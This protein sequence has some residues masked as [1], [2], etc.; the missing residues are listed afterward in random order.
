MIASIPVPIDVVSRQLISAGLSVLPAS[1]STK[2]PHTAALPKGGDG[3][4]TWNPFRTRYATDTELTRWQ[5]LGADIPAIVYGNQSRVE[6]FDVDLKGDRA[7][8]GLRFLDR[9]RAAG[10]GLYPR[11]VIWRSKSGGMHIPIGYEGEIPGNHQIARAYSPHATDP[12]KVNSVALV[13]TRGEGGYGIFWPA[14]GC[15]VLQGDPLRPPVLTK[16]E[17]TLIVDVALGFE[18]GLEHFHAAMDA[19]RAADEAKRAARKGKGQS[20]DDGDGPA[21]WFNR[22]ATI[23]SMVSLL[24]EEG[25]TIAVQRGGHVEVTRTGKDPHD[26]QSGNIRYLGDRIVFYNHSTGW[27]AFGVGGYSSFGVYAV[28][29]HGGSYSKAGS[30]IARDPEYIRYELDRAEAAHY[31]DHP[32]EDFGGHERPVDGAETGTSQ[33]APDHDN[34]GGA[35]TEG[36]PKL[37][38]ISITDRPLRDVTADAL[39]ALGGAPDVY[40]RGGI[41]VRMQRDDDMRPLIAPLGID[42]MA[43]EL[44]RCAE[45]ARMDGRTK[46]FVVTDPPPRVV[47]DVLT[48]PSY[49]LR[50]LAGIVEVPVVRADGSILATTGYDVGSRLIYD[51]DPSLRVPPVPDKP[52][53]ADV[54]RART[55][56]VDELLGEFPFA[57]DSDRAHAAALL[58]EGFLLVLIDGP[59]PMILID[60]PSAGTGK[61]LIADML[62]LPAFGTAVGNLSEAGDDAEWRKRLTALFL[63]GTRLVRVDNITQPLESASLAMALT[64]G[65]WEDRVLGASTM[66]RVP[67]R[68]VW[69]ATGNNVVASTDIARRMVPIRL[70]AQMERPWLRDGFRHQDLRGWA[71]DHRGDLV[72]AALILIRA[73]VNAGMPAG[74]H[75]R[76]GSYESWSRVVGGILHHAGIAGFLGNLDNLYASADNELERWRAFIG[77][78]WDAHNGNDVPVGELFMLAKD[79]DWPFRSDR[80]QAQRTEFGMALG[81]QQKRVIGNHRVIKA[82][83]VRGKTTWRLTVAAFG[84]DPGGLGGGP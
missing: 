62:V 45:F 32:G 39:R 76:L 20:P 77:L 82:G 68:C 49:D 36:A 58:L 48:R 15:E 25:A 19:A 41:L 14:G 57:G 81:R 84:G 35:H 29:K 79:M 51:P 16:E 70:D 4:A 78:W 54:V 72:A 3:K 83:M 33:V 23:D 44:A 71:L 66:V 40:Q 18:E 52:T 8:L 75:P 64:T 65:Y 47:R 26:G 12:T 53:R 73:W 56:I 1:T 80:D 67:V 7:H 46:R 21:E 27:P 13:E 42:A 10:P 38:A 30:A 9:L 60:A 37:P 69:T 59:T 74:E 24:R 5:A 61:G 50:T 17:R 55:L 6:L 43:G 11:L 28:V 63:R 34:T 31:R 2:Q 22:R